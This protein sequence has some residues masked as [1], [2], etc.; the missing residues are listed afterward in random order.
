MSSIDQRTR[1]SALRTQ[2]VR[3]LRDGPPSRAARRSRTRRA[4]C[5]V[6]RYYDPATDQFI[7]VDPALATTGQPYAFAGNNPINA[8]DP[9]GLQGSVFGLSSFW[10]GAGWIGSYGQAVASGAADPAVRAYLAAVYAQQQAVNAYLSSKYQS[11]LRS[12][13][14]G[15]AISAR[16]P[17]FSVATPS[18]VFSVSSTI[19][20]ERGGAGCGKPVLDGESI[21]MSCGGASASFSADGAIMSAAT[22]SGL[23]LSASGSGLA[24]T[25]TVQQGVGSDNVSIAFSATANPN[26]S[27]G[28]SVGEIVV[29][30]AIAVGTAIS[31]AIWT[32]VRD[33]CEFGFC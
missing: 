11:S 18:I 8:T 22:S 13:P 12:S 15:V 2:S 14:Y 7:T 21:V 16:G 23:G 27:S 9:L 17:S 19:T 20:I 26:G 25:D 30:G 4:R 10:L 3:G 28:P 6:H 33:P 5:A 1:A 32:V 24:A 31:V 29:G